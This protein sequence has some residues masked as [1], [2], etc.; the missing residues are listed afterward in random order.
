MDGKAAGDVWFRRET[1]YTEAVTRDH[2]DNDLI[3][4]VTI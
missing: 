3:Y 4:H 1:Q 2:E